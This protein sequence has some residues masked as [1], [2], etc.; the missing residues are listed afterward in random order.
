M[1]TH[2]SP[3]LQAPLDVTMEGSTEGS[4]LTQARRRA[5]IYQG[6][7]GQVSGAQLRGALARACNV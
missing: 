1:D 7:L 4:H 3:S 6:D 5:G 2:F